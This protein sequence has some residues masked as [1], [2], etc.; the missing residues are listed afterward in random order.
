M[1]RKTAAEE[2]FMNLLKRNVMCTTRG[3]RRMLFYKLPRNLRKQFEGLKVENS[4]N[5]E[6][7]ILECVRGLCSSDVGVSHNML[8]VKACKIA[9][10]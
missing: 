5:F 3:S 4:L 6:D 2:P 10:S 9:I 8:F 7:E 1:Q